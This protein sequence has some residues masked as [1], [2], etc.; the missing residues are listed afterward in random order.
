M[1]FV[2]KTAKAS[3]LKTATLVLPVGEGR[4]LGETAQ[5]VDIA[6]GGVIGSILKRGDLDGKVG[7]TLLLH[8]LPNLKAERV[9][10]LGVGKNNELD[11]RQWR[12]ALGAAAG[13]LKSLGGSDAAFAVQDVQVK[14]RDTYAKVRLLAELLAD[15][16]YV[17][18]RFKSKKADPRAL[19]KVV[20]LCDKSQQDDIER[21]VR[22]AS[23]I[24]SGMALT[25][26]LG[27]LPPNLCHPSF[28]A[29]QARQLGKSFKGL[30]V[31]VLDEKKLRDLGAGA[32]L[33]VAQGS[34][35]PGCIVVMQY[36]GGA[37][38]E[39]P[40]ALVGKGITFDTGGISLKPGL[41]M[42]EMKYDMCGA[43]SVLGTFRAVL[44]LQLPINLVGLLACAENMPSGKAT[45]PGDIVTTL[46]GQT[47]EILNTDAE[48]R[49]VLCDTLTYA[50][51]FKPR[52]VIDV[53][54]LTGACIVALG[55]HTSGLLGN[56][57]ELAQQLLGAGEQAGDR[58]WQLPLF[59]EYQEQLDSPFADIANIGGPKAG[60]VTA[61]CFLSRF[62]KQYPWAHL[63]I[64]GTAWISGG[65]EKGATGRPVPL[66]TQYLLDRAI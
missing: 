58:A 61:A 64:A 13:V 54:T 4:T 40:Y 15:S 23:A 59:D 65:K 19:K 26:D 35:Q 44:E 50:E 62:T 46:S 14:G 36:N 3:A 30:K 5:A 57:Q 20:L 32:F 51:R 52:A 28:M 49:L 37:K 24:A 63:D 33:A 2:V 56:D 7:Q 27:N 6:S 38:G 25:R 31:D 12:K 47:V 11:T 53:A 1:E 48:G 9:L 34:E 16:A 18:E 42:D 29:E 41:G 45:R 66:L 22:H 8:S 43:A 17:F 10:L 21:A 55:S 60:T 39:Q